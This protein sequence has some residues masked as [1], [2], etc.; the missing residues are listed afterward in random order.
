MWSCSARRSSH[1]PPP[2][3]TDPGVQVWRGV[4]EQRACVKICPSQT[5]QEPWAL[6]ALGV[7]FAASCCKAGL[8]R[9]LR[10]SRGGARRALRRSDGAPE[11]DAPS[12]AEEATGSPCEAPQKRQRQQRQ[13]S[14]RRR[15]VLHKQEAAPSPPHARSPSPP[16]FP[17]STCVVNRRRRIPTDANYSRLAKARPYYARP[18]PRPLPRR[19]AVIGTSVDVHRTLRE[20]RVSLCDEAVVGVGHFT[21]ALTCTQSISSRSRYMHRAVHAQLSLYKA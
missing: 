10:A 15:A 14:A 11:E 4:G 18:R 6:G 13:P 3:F 21:A 20:I 12:T 5:G 8:A 16:R 7:R 1:L 19:L 2:Y 17:A 9:N